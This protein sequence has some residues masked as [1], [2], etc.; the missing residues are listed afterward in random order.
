MTT[1]AVSFVQDLAVIMIAAAVGG[2]LCRRLGLSPVVGYLLAGMAVGPFTPDWLGVVRDIDRVRLFAE[3]G[4]V[5][6]MFG[7]GL[8]F[9]LKRLQQMGLS[10]VVVAGGGAL[11]VFTMARALGEGLGLDRVGGM[12]FGALLV[13][14][15]SAVIGKLLSDSGTSHD[16]SSQLALGVTLAEDIVAIVALTLLGSMLPG[17]TGGASVEIGRTVALF[18]GF[19]LVL[20]TLGLLVVPR[21]LRWLGREA[22]LELQT[23]FV[24]GLL[25]A[26]ALM[27]VK[28]GYSLALGAFLLGAIVAETP[29]RP[30]LERAFSGM[31]DLFGAIFFVAIGMSIPV[32]ALPEMG[33]TIALTLVVAVV[34]RSVAVAVMLMLLGQDKVTA[35]RAGLILTPLGEFSFVIAQMGIDGGALPQAYLA[36][37]VGTALGTALLG[38]VLVRHGER[39][40]EMIA[41]RSWPGFDTMLSLHHRLIA[42]LQQ[43]RDRNLLWKLLRRRITQISIEVALVTAL[44]VL[45]KPGVR[46]AAQKWGEDAVPLIGTTAVLGAVLALLVVVPLIAI[47][48]NLQAV[49]M[50]LADYLSRQIVGWRRIRGLMEAM[51]FWPVVVGL[52]LWLWNVSPVEGGVWLASGFVGLMTVTGALFWR[53]FIR[54]HSE[55]EIVLE[56][57]LG[58]GNE[59]ASTPA[60]VDRY[61]PWGLHL[62]E[63]E[64]PDQF[65]DAGRTLRQIDLRRRC[66][67]VVIAIERRGFRINNPGAEASLFGGDKVLLLGTRA[68]IATA[69]SLLLEPKST[70]NGKPAAEIDALTVELAV[71]PGASATVGQPL[72]E[73][74]WPGRFGV[75]VLGVERDGKR[76][77]S[78]DAGFVLRA[79]D[80]LL[81]MGAA[82]RL[83]EVERELATERGGDLPPFSD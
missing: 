52:S 48:R 34:G 35:L 50:I 73:L 15:S 16:K 74:A 79:G 55:M 26:V 5:F 75:Q 56:S 12:F 31:R 32:A 9:S 66:E 71:V 67:V 64:L 6:L 45:A 58:D 17:D 27:V 68:Q 49:A 65:A 3:L 63:L 47:L 80:C 78:P 30:Q 29:Q 40:A 24:A 76:Q 53:H 69:K 54:W 60:W 22:N 14:S 57:S 8:S 2:L 39:I 20:A 41:G 77:L 62:G 61:A 81:L 72:S 28:A 82:A 18:A 44:L 33:G 43:R 13:V 37:A 70:E 23:L 11:L 19:V 7:I 21:V 83:S 51:I 25:F 10:V 46:L 42:G 59:T 1:E 4:L 36:V 38:P